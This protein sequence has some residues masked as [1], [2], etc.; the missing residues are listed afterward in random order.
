MIVRDFSW[1]TF[2]RSQDISSF[3]Y[4]LLTTLNFNLRR[5]YNIF[6][7]SFR[8]TLIEFKLLCGIDVF[9]LGDIYCHAYTD[10]FLNIEN[11]FLGNQSIYYREYDFKV[12]DITGRTLLDDESF[13]FDF[14]SALI[15]KSVLYWP[16]SQTKVS[17]RLQKSNLSLNTD[18]F[19][20][21]NHL[22]FIE[23]YLDEKL[24]NCSLYHYTS[25]A[26]FFNGYVNEEK[27]FWRKISKF[28]STSDFGLRH[29]LSI[30]A[31][32]QLKVNSISNSTCLKIL[33]FYLILYLNLLILNIVYLLNLFEHYFLLVLLF[34]F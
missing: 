34:Q 5:Y 8:K 1:E 24:V 18:I 19:S 21:V 3:S 12:V 23:W 6:V 16:I 4:M 28:N 27:F 14:E 13:L 25:S 10:V 17:S 2:N 32:P 9:D 22:D 31:V 11:W 33:I 20:T 7:G 30:I 29:L 15:R 26:F